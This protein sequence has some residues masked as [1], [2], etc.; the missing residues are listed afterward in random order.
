[1]EKL[2]LN[3]YKNIY[4]V[5]NFEK[6]LA[7]VLKGYGKT[8]HFY[9]WFY[10]RLSWMEQDISIAMRAHPKDFKKIS[11]KKNMYELRY[12]NQKKCIRILFSIDAYGKILLCPFEEKSTADF[13]AVEIAEARR[14]SL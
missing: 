1:M 2:K 7:E 14:K 10:N 12:R 13:R 6:E 5:R 11:G 9:E 8:K 4:M 3:P